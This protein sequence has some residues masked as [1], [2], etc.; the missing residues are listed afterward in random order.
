MKMAEK[1]LSARKRSGFTLI[2][3]LV[4]IA[5]IAILAGMLMPALNKA[6]AS[7]R[8]SNCISNL[9]QL[10]TVVQVYVDTFDGFLMPYNQT[11]VAGTKV[12]AWYM[13]DTWISNYLYKTTLTTAEVGKLKVMQCPEVP[14]GVTVTYDTNYMWKHRSYML[15]SCVS[16][17]ESLKKINQIKMPSKVPNIVDGTGASVYTWSSKDHVPASSP[18]TTDSKKSR[19]VD[20]RHNGRCNIVTVAGS[21]TDTP[22]LPIS[23]TNSENIAVLP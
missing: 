7:A 11:V 15:N 20:Y 8:K 1:T 23:S 2:E 22:D 17:V 16:N 13:G 5:I 4:V 12:R 19:R 18:L 9:K 21:V 6:R 10:G 14:D 3:L